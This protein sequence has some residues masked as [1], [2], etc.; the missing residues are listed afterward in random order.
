MKISIFTHMTNP[1]ERM[2]PWREA[3]ECYEYFCDEVVTVGENWPYE[4]DWKEIGQNFQEGFEK[5]DGDWV[6]NMPLDFFFHEKSRNQ[7]LSSLKEHDDSPAIAIP[8]FKFFSPTKYEFKNFEIIVLNK[9]KFPNIRLDGGG[10]LCLATLDGKL[11][12]YNALPIVNIPIWNYD[13]T[14]RTKEVIAE[15]RARF[16]RA[17][18]R[19]FN[20]W[21]DRGGPEPIEAF[22]A[23]LNM[24]K[25]R[26]PKH[27]SKIET[28]K[29]PKFIQDAIFNLKEE[30]FGYNCFGLLNKLSLNPM[31]YFDFLKLKMKF[32]NIKLN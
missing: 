16:A 24:V 20:E 19:H 15:D 8:K 30:Q 7:L 12:D 32:P 10:D 6:I 5:A 31:V 2:D 3:L 29:H 13:T 17:W 23:W 9:K 25:E 22:D 4:F 28:E 21:G 11:I 26:L 14:F 27:I 18:F 1:E